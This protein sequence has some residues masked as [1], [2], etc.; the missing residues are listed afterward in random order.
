MSRRLSFT[1]K[2]R[3]RLGLK[4]DR[5]DQ[6]ETRNTITEPISLLGLSL[7]ALRGLAQIGLMDPNDASNALSGLARPGQATGQGRRPA[8]QAGAAPS[9][10]IPIVIGPQIKHPAPAGGG[11]GGVPSNASSRLRRPPHGP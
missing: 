10:F 6:L 5:L 9:N 2:R 8:S 4:V 11:G 1:E 7:S 3:A